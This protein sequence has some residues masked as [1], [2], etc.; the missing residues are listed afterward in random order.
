MA[1]FCSY[2]Q[3]KNLTIKMNTGSDN[4]NIYIKDIKSGQVMESFKPLTKNSWENNFVFDNENIKNYMFYSES[5]I[6]SDFWN[7]IDPLENQGDD[8][9]CCLIGDAGQ[10]N[11]CVFNGAYQNYPLCK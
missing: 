9:I 2:S 5:G 4:V 10:I 11:Y 3:A 7:M 6:H 8:T 1:S